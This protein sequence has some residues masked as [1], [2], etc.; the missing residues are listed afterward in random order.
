MNDVKLVE[1]KKYNY[2]DALRGIA[3][4]GTL[5]VHCS[6]YEHGK[7]NYGD[8]FKRITFSG[9]NGVQLF[10]LMSAFTLFMSYY[11]KK[12]KEKNTK[13]NFFIRRFFRIAPLFYVAIVMYLMI[14]GL[15]PRYWLGDQPSITP[16][17]LISTI[18]F[19]NFINPYWINSVVEGGLVNNY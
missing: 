2:I 19:S 13:L 12:G 15:G 5:M 18:T 16:F 7:N 6:I 8:I 3:V 14:N 4:L 17:N 11:Q 10:F 1:V 9:S